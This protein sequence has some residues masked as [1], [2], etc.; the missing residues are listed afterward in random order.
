MKRQTDPIHYFYCHIFNFLS[1][2][3]FQFIFPLFFQPLKK[4]CL[5]TEILG[6]II[7]LCIFVLFFCLLLHRLAVIGSVC[8]FIFS[9]NMYL[10]IRLRDMNRILQVK[11]NQHIPQ[12]SCKF[13]LQQRHF[14]FFFFRMEIVLK[15]LFEEFLMVKFTQLLLVNIIFASQA[16]FIMYTAGGRRGGYFLEGQFF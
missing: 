6:N 5:Q 15:V 2:T 14:S 3:N 13:N 8:H 1:V 7:L 4:V 9:Q 10:A 11:L 12:S 16:A